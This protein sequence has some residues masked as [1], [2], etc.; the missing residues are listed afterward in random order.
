MRVVTPFGELGGS[1]RWLLTMLEATDRL[2]ADVVVL[3]PGPLLD[4]LARRGIRARLRLTGRRAWDLAAANRWLLTDLRC[5]RPDVVLANGVKAAA[6][7]APACRLTGTPVVWVNHDSS[8]ARGLARPL[9]RPVDR[10]VATV[11]EVGVATG[12]DDVTVVVPPRAPGD[13]APRDD[14]RRFWQQRGVA[15][16][17]GPTAV[18]VGRLD[19]VKGVDDA[20]AALALPGAAGWQLVV[21][22]EERPGTDERRRL[23][24]WADVRGVA[25]RVQFTGWVEDPGHHLGAFDAL[26]LLTKRDERGFG[27]EGFGIAALEAMLAGVPVIAAE[28]GAVVR[29]LDGPC[30][31]SGLAVPPA[32]PEAVARAL[33]EI[34]DPERRRAMGEAGR[35]SVAEHPGAPVCAAQLV[36]V[37]AEVAARPG[38][39]FPDS[40]PGPV[41]VATPVLNE[42]GE[43]DRVASVVVGQLR[44]GDEY[45]IVEAGSTD[46]TPQRAAAWAARCPQIRVLAWTG[47]GTLNV[48]RGR[49]WAVEEATHEV[50]AF[51]DAGC[52]PVPGWL[53]ALR[54]PFGD[55]PR[56]DFVAGV[57]RAS[58]HGP[59]EAA[60]AAAA[61]MDPDDARRPTLLTRAYGRAFGRRF[62]PRVPAGRS[63]AFTRA[64][65]RDAG[66]FRTD[67]PTN[68]DGV[69]AHAVAANG[70]RLVLQS[71]AEVGW[72]QGLNARATA[73]MWY[74]YG[75]GDGLSGDRLA[76]ARDLVRVAAYATGPG[77]L[78]VGGRAGRVA[79]VAGAAAYLSLPLSRARRMPR[80]VATGLLAPVALAVKD[81][82][83][84]AGCVVG[85]ARAARSGSGQP[86]G[87]GSE[88]P[89][90]R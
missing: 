88:A 22:G 77:L 46:D 28:G 62:E 38:A 3:G 31:R 12:R 21:V 86:L 10:V 57:Y 16:A 32:D 72:E 85:L 37:L 44:P 71:E 65:W 61:H 50:V 82:G 89:D 76:V 4:E 84:G 24:S 30:G 63:M 73:R 59:F 58:T 11:E 48:A 39:G 49:N 54:R 42:G 35:R 6:A 17:G 15:F 18:A 8:W 78:A 68:E 33:G 47:P 67:I 41:T 14:A 34:A 79:A 36:G 43:L 2:D 53:V 20:I 25:G 60:T 56:P 70:A 27:F 75:R 29:R 9:G 80:P 83:L 87:A 66:G 13:P 1:E 7:V 45:L 64:A 55:E 19:P 81:V 90:G 74:R 52:T 5:A 26:V 69:F 51:T 23:E 40:H